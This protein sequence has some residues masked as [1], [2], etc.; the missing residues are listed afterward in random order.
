MGKR[1]KSPE[2]VPD[3]PLNVSVIVPV[4]V[5]VDVTTTYNSAVQVTVDGDPWGP[6]TR[7]PPT[8]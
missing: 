3:K 2:P 1:R 5:N 7:P 4:G 8:T 6:P